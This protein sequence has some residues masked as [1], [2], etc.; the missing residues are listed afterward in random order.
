MNDRVKIMLIGIVAFSIFTAAGVYAF[1]LTEIG[2]VDAFNLNIFQKF[3]T[4]NTIFYLII[5]GAFFAADAAVIAWLTNRL[6]GWDSAIV[7][8]IG[9]GIAL[10]FGVGAN[11]FSTLYNFTIFMFFL[12]L[13]SVYAAHSNWD[14]S[15]KGMSR[16]K[17]VYSVSKK[18]MTIMAVG[19][20]VGGVMITYLDAPFYQG[21]VKSGIVTVASGV[22]I[23]SLITE[24]NVRELVISQELSRAELEEFYMGFCSDDSACSTLPLSAQETFVQ[25]S[26]DTALQAQTDNRDKNVDNFYTVLQK[27]NTALPDFTANIIENFPLTKAMLDILPLLTGL[28]LY[29]AISVFGRIVVGPFAALFGLFVKK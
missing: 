27:R 29:S 28:I 5:M 19:G 3:F 8:I 24:E 23:G 7:V 21:M 9:M 17:T 15:G 25:Q 6:G 18:V 4:G 16:A 14:I 10:L 2:F 26:T 22:N 13:G 12:L 20:L 11:L 1:S